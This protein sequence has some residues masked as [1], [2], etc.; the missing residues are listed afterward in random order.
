MR[1][2]SKVQIQRVLDAKSVRFL[3]VGGSAFVVNAILLTVFIEGFNLQTPLSRNIANL[4]AIQLSIVF[5]FELHRRAT[6]R[7]EQPVKGWAL[8]R[9]F[10]AYEVSIGFALVLRALLFA[11]LDWVGLNYLINLAVGVIVVSGISYVIYD[12]VVFRQKPSASEP[13]LEKNP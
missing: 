10:L 12:K 9:Q 8:V 3:L 2:P 13:Q 4:I 6:F 5:S 11:V 1:L 7:L